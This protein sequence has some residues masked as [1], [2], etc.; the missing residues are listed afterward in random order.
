[1]DKLRCGIILDRK[2][3]ILMFCR[4]KRE[5]DIEGNMSKERLTARVLQEVP[6]SKMKEIKF[7]RLSS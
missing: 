7:I 2:K 1:M 5:E 6:S 3:N 4:V